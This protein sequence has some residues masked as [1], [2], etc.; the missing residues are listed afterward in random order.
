MTGIGNQLFGGKQI[1][2]GSKGLSPSQPITSA[3][4]VKAAKQDSS[5][6][7]KEDKRSSLGSQLGSALPQ[8]ELNTTPPQTNAEQLADLIKTGQY[9]NAENLIAKMSMQEVK[10][11]DLGQYNLLEAQA[12]QLEGVLSGGS[13]GYSP[14][15]EALMLKVVLDS[16]L[17]SDDIKLHALAKVVRSERDPDVSVDQAIGEISSSSLG[18]YANYDAKPDTLKETRHAYTQALKLLMEYKTQN[19]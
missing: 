14:E 17:M 8:V 16:K 6:H 3:A 7:I 11:V 4:E 5:T 15:E 12:D 18:R 13:G 9:Q 2:I 10:S 1:I 19:P